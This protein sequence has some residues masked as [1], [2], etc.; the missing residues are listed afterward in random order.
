M[1]Q[2]CSRRF[3]SAGNCGV[4][5]LAGGLGF[6][7]RLAESESEKL[8]RHNPPQ[9]LCRHQISQLSS[10]WCRPNPTCTVAAKIFG[11]D[12]VPPWREEEHSMQ[13]KVT[14]RV[15]DGVEPR[16]AT[17][18][19]RDTEVKGFVLVVTP[20]GATSYAVD[21]RAG[22]GR[23][24]PKGRLIIGKHGSPRTPE[25]AR[26]EA[27]RLLAEVAAG[28]DPATARQKDRKA[29]TFD[30]LIDLYL[31][32]RVNH[33]KAS[34]LKADRGRI[35]HHLR[36]LLGKLRA[37]RIVRADVERMRNA[38]TAGKTVERIESGEKRQ[39]GS[40]ARGGKGAAAQCVPLVS[41]IF[42]FAVERGLYA[43]NPARGVNSPSAQGR[44]LPVGSGDYSA[45]RGARRGSA[46][47]GQ[48]LPVRR[49][50]AV[51]ADRVPSRRDR[52]SVLGIRRFRAR[53]PAAPRQQDRREG[54]VFQCSIPRVA[55]GTPAHRGQPASV[56]WHAVR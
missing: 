38:V 33:K 47:I 43:D 15:V 34:T 50:Q 17:Y 19:V 23:G 4:R 22:S 52:Q 48:S 7:P 2:S 16:E 18:L 36:P 25:T 8:R 30:D 39:S 11:A 26:V 9:A 46:T 27:K 21:Y 1:D 32:E 53:V 10:L 45:C 56:P 20:A 54:G 12:M 42:A 24:S 55:P 13:A 28:R 5:F 6:E 49:D 41:S 51:A 44:A 31:S 37:E 29:L 40:M 3:L 35:E 14:K